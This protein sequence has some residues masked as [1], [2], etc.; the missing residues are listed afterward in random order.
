MSRGLDSAAKRAGGRAVGSVTRGK[1]A[2]VLLENSGGSDTVRAIEQALPPFA[3]EK[4]ALPRGQHRRQREV[5]IRRQRPKILELGAEA[6]LGSLRQ[7]RKQKSAL[8][9]DGW[10][11]RRHERHIGKRYPEKLDAG[12]FE[13]KHL[14]AL[15]VNDA[16]GLDLPKRRLSRIIF[17]GFAC[18]IDAVLQ[19]GVVAAGAVGAC[20]GKTSLVGRFE[21]QRI[22]KSVAIVVG[23]IDNLAIRDLAVRLGQPDVALSAQPLGFL[24]VYDLIGFDCRAAVIELHAADRGNRIVGVVVS[25]LGRLYEHRSV[26]R[27]WW[28]SRRRRRPRRKVHDA[29]GVL[30]GN[31]L[32]GRDNGP[33]HESKQRREARNEH[34]G[35]TSAK[36]TRRPTPGRH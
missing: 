15:I 26:R 33:E 27:R 35:A 31:K 16:G 19:D 1:I 17:A 32:R 10:I 7:A 21:S 18:G 6:I 34:A 36:R 3:L 28:L 2:G 24:I 13:I 30:L 25:D 22:D 12:V 8:A 11:G 9:F 5:V 4:R 29:Q 20:R 14:L 23:Q